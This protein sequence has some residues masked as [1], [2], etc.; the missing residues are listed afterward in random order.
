M[1]SWSYWQTEPGVWLNQWR[2][3]CTDERVLQQLKRLPPS[4]Y[5]A[6]AGVQMIALCWGERENAAVLQDVAQFLKTL[7]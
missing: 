6:E 1:D 2:E 5:K 4:V 7:A 3:P